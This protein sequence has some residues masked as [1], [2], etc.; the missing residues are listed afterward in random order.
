MSSETSVLHETA[1]RPWWMTALAFF[2]FGSVLFLIPRDLFFSETRDVEVW[3][4]FEVRGTAALLTAPIHWTIFLL[5]AWGF[6]HRR[7]WILPCAAAYV[8]Y[9]ALSHLIWSE[10]SPNGRGWPVGLAQ[11]VA[12]SVAGI[13]LLRARRLTRAR[14]LTCGNPTAL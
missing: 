7:P 1:P 6:W 10:A 2:C 8:F 11:A 12:I 3:L 14:Q 9:I 5:G 13:L 4:G